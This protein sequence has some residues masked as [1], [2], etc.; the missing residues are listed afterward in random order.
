MS[1]PIRIRPA[2]T[3]ADFRSVSA[4]LARMQAWDAEMTAATG[5]GDIDLA[6]LYEDSHPAG[7]QATF[8]APGAGMIVADRGGQILG[9]IGYSPLGQ[10][11][12]EVCKVFVDDSAR[13]LGLGREM[14]VRVLAAMAAAGHSRAV[15]ETATFMTTAIALYQAQ[16]FHPSPPFRPAFNSQSL[17]FARDLPPAGRDSAGAT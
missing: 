16:G 4:L 8:T 7:I 1:D 10:G 9:C 13:G 2:T 14:M 15:L 17:F 3:A 11:M 6:P 5:G 12:A